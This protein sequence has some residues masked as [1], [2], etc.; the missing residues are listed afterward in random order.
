MK[1]KHESVAMGPTLATVDEK[2]WAALAQ[3]KTAGML[4]DSGCT[5]NILT[6]IEAFID[7]QSVVRN[8]NREATRVVDRG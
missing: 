2:Y 1:G 6:N 5:D 3:W 4:V 7:N 8:S